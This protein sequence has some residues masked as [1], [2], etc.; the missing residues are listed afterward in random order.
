[1]RS[2]RIINRSDKRGRRFGVWE[3]YY[4]NGKLE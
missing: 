3:L 1:M 4:D 2:L